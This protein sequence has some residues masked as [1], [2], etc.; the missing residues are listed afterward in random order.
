V[1]L[2]YERWELATNRRFI[3]MHPTRGHTKDEIP[4]RIGSYIVMAMNGPTTYRATEEYVFAEMAKVGEKVGLLDSIKI[5]PE[6]D[7]LKTA[8]KSPV[9]PGMYYERKPVKL[10]IDNVPE[11]NTIDKIKDL[12]EKIIDKTNGAR[13]INIKDRKPHQP[14]KRRTISIRANGLA[15]INICVDMNAVIPYE[16]VEFRTNLYV[17]VNRRPY[18]CNDCFALG[19]HPK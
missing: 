9:A 12:I 10:E 16:E 4:E 17:K 18:Q 13:I 15:F 8:L 11:N 6:D 5:S 2:R 3:T 7:I 19:F 1:G 14:T